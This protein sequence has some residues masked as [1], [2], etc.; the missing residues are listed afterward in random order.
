MA[1]PLARKVVID[2]NIFIDYL[3]D[4]ASSEWVFGSTGMAIRFLSSVVLMELRLGA[5]TLKRRRAVERIRQA[6]PRERIIA[7][8]AELFEHA[9]DLFRRLYSAGAEP[10][11]RLAPIN[12]LLIALTAWRI[13]AAV[14]TR[15]TVDFQRIQRHLPGL[16]IVA[17]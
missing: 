3:R 2:T 15:N 1:V 13:G 8:S 17:P 5:D 7:P 6:F 12:D 16:R 10:A 9:A 14:V 11:D 4:D